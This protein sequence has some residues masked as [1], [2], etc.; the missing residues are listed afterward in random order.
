MSLQT[1][2]M[3]LTDTTTAFLSYSPLGNANGDPRTNA[4]A[5]RNYWKR[6]AHGDSNGLFTFYTGAAAGTAVLTVSSTGS[7]NNDTG[8]VAGVTFTAKTSGATGN[9]FNI[10]ST[11]GTQAANMVAAFNASASLVGLVTAAN[12]A[13]V[14]TLTA[15]VPGA[16]GNLLVTTSAWTNVAVT[17]SFATAA[18]GSNGTLY[19]V[20]LR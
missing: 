3:N 5:F 4:D 6:L 11:P 14:I 18:T 9:Q 13:G 8:V 16:I 1:L 10:S 15:S 12:V 19:T 20:D 7:S 2:V 17:T